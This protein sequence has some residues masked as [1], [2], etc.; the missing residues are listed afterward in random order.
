MATLEQYLEALIATRTKA[1]LESLDS[2]VQPKTEYQFGYVCGVQAGL[3]MAEELLNKQ[4]TEVE[5]DG[6]D[7]RSQ[8]TRRTR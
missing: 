1:A 2:N 8:R 3:R 6:N 5:D 7:T 4:L